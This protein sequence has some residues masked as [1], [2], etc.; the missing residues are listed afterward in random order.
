MKPITR[1]GLIALAA[2]AI[3]ACGQTQDSETNAANDVIANEVNAIPA[4]PTAPT[5]EPATQPPGNDVKTSGAVANE[6]AGHDMN[7]SQ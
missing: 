4:E 7:N 2:V 5:N 6:H 3:A 1:T